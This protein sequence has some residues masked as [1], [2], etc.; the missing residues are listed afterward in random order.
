MKTTSMPGSVIDLSI[1]GSSIPDPVVVDT[2]L[3]VER[4][5][6]PF[7]GLLP[8]SPTL[9]AARADQFFVKLDQSNATGLIT[10]TVFN[11]FVH[12]AI[13]FRYR[14]ELLHRGEN[15]NTWTRLYKQDPSILHAFGPQ[16][17]HLRRLII[18]NDLLLVTPED[19][20]PAR[21]VLRFDE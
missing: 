7:L 14:Q 5:I 21:S 16:L 1:S 8:A 17:D 13:K 11:E 6:V 3:L 4:L 10:P 20:G 9:E 18:A 15:P 19:L 12:V 2:N